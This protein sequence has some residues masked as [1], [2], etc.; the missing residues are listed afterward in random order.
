MQSLTLL[1]DDVL[2][3]IGSIFDP[4]E[5]PLILMTGGLPPALKKNAYH[6][7]GKARRLQKWWK[8]VRLP[9]GYDPSWCL[10]TDNEW[11]CSLGERMYKRFMITRFP[12]EHMKSHSITLAW[13]LLDQADLIHN[14]DDDDEMMMTMMTTMMMIDDDNDDDDDFTDRVVV[15]ID[16]FGRLRLWKTMVKMADAR[17]LGTI[18]L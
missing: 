3:F 2:S 10:T 17:V 11:S 14:D 9:S 12:L 8:N 6:I 5:A 13:A 4:S 15:K 16:I 1:S 18:G 7:V